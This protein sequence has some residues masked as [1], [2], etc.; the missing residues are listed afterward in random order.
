MGDAL[1]AKVAEMLATA[2]RL[3]TEINTTL[4]QVKGTIDSLRSPVD[5]LLK[6]AEGASEKYVRL[7]AASGSLDAKVNALGETLASI[8]R[9]IEAVDSSLAGSQKDFDRSIGINALRASISQFSPTT[10]IYPDAASVSP[11]EFF[12]EMTMA[13]AEGKFMRIGQLANTYFLLRDS[14][15]AADLIALSHG[16]LQLNRSQD[17][18]VAAT[19]GLNKLDLPNQPGDRAL[20]QSKLLSKRALA[21]D[22]VGDRANAKTDLYEAL[23][24]RENNAEALNTLGSILFE[25]GDYDGAI[26]VLERAVNS[27][28][29]ADS[30]GIS[31]LSCNLALCCLL[32]CRKMTGSDQAIALASAEKYANKAIE[33]A[34]TK[35]GS[36]DGKEHGSALLAMAMVQAQ[37]GQNSDARRYYKKALD[38]DRS[39]K[40]QGDRLGL[41]DEVE[42]LLAMI[43]EYGEKETVDKH[44]KSEK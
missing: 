2:K 31:K 1:S 9:H 39:I 19:L 37:K 3:E 18:V 16:L 43:A 22:A 12:A 8:G 13:I 20:M 15:D 10:P 11:D 23:K 44:G 25:E 41:T 29:I 32:R 17:A 38:Q 30:D 35:R 4:A 7:E 6:T 28:Q 24:H 21:W 40:L 27:A 36:A 14:L 26:A 34:A 33:A 5:G 42:T